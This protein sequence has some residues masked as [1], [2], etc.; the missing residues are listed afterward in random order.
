MA[1]V[2]WKTG[3]SSTW[4]TA[5][6][7]STGTVPTAADDVTISVAGTYTVTTAA[8]DS[9]NSLTLNDATATL[10]ISKSTLTLGTLNDIA[11]KIT[12]AAK[13]ALALTGTQ[14]TA[15]LGASNITSS[16]TIDFNGVLNNTGAT[17]NIGTGGIGVT[18]LAGKITGGTIVDGGTVVG[19]NVVSAM[20]FTAGAG[21]IF[22]G[23]TYDGTLSLTGQAVGLEVTSANGGLITHAQS[24]TGNG[25]IN[26]T[27]VSQPVL[28]LDDTQ[29]LNNATVNFG[30]VA[31]PAIITQNDTGSTPGTLTFGSGLTINQVGQGEIT[32]TGGGTVVGDTV[33][34]A[35]AINAAVAKS[36]LT[37]DPYAF[38]NQGSV[39]VGAAGDKVFVSAK[40][41]TNSSTGT[42]TVTAG[43]L[44]LGAGT[45][46]GSF[47]NHG[48]I[49]VGAAGT[50]ELDLS[51][52][53][54]AQL[55][56]VANSG[57]LLI[58][59]VT[60]LDNTGATLS[61]GTGGFAGPSTVVE[62]TILN[63]TIVDS[64]SG[65]SFIGGKLSNV[66]YDGTLN[67]GASASVFVIGN[68]TANNAAGTGPGT[69]N[70]T[71][72]F[73]NLIFQD[74]QTID[75]ATINIGN[76]TAGAGNSL[77]A[78]PSV[79]G[80]TNTLT[81]GK[82][83]IINHVGTFAGITQNSG[84][85]SPYTV[86]NEGTIKASLAGGTLSI[87]PDNFSNQGTIAVSNG[88]T[89]DSEAVAST[90]AT[91][92]TNAAG[93]SITIG[94][95]ST[96]D[97]GINAAT[98]ALYSAT[99]SGALTLAGG[100]ITDGGTLTDAAGGSIAGFGTVSGAVA[101]GGKFDAS[102]GTLTFSGAVTGTGTAFVETGAKL[103]FGASV[104]A[105]QAV[106][107]VGTGELDLAT[108][109]AFAGTI[110]G[111]SATDTVDLTT[112]GFDS[113]GHANLLAGNVLQVTENGNTYNLQL[114]P[115]Q[116]FSGEFFHLAADLS[117]TG[118]AIT[119]STLP[120]YCRGTQILTP[121]GEVAVEELVIGDQIVTHTGA[122]RSIKWLGRRSYG[123]RFVLGRKDILPVCI[124][125]G[126]LAENV[127]QRDLWISPQHAMYLDGVLIEA[128]DLVN[129]VSVVQA[130]SVNAVD[131]FH[132]ELDSHDVII[133]EGAL[134]ESFIDDNGRGMFQN[135]HEYRTLYADAAEEQKQ[136]CAPRCYDGDEL[137]A[138]RRRVAARAGIRAVTEAFVGRGFVDVA[139]PHRITGWAQNAQHP[140]VP[141]CLDVV[142]GGTRIGS[143]LA[144]R[145][146][147]D[148]ELKGLGSGNHGFEFVLPPGLVVA[149][150][151]VEVRRSYDGALLPCSKRMNQD[152]VELM[153]AAS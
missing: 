62:G 149:A 102:G 85:V 55:G 15:A 83:L 95:G 107:L 67:L 79:T 93:G 59:P 120:C 108:P 42:M 144:N 1:A 89:I 10:A 36:A 148:L 109:A 72:T 132:V 151:A 131:Y 43:T 71:G 35:G 65:M 119:E 116:N 99:N 121:R 34:N 21:G 19:K 8:A 49:T 47:A 106:N 84:N 25:T 22:D 153:R 69:I 4:E 2:N 90:L 129:G 30:N 125:A 127:P 80:Q 64:A 123:G 14:T 135:G 26:L 78:T 97:L 111:I 87:M 75:N 105:G 138:V 126:A 53:T 145:H 140:E 124:K 5:A 23:V 6:N 27:G 28:T 41:F 61:V 152:G 100:T 74:T 137:E 134:S 94:A 136:Y 114:D 7:W 133:A 130:E 46:S 63:G 128:R 29:T 39:T 143:M 101:N 9:A 17:L 112:V 147:A 141:V 60:T 48:T 115:T 117:G 118:T 142:I 20:S 73:A 92:F 13:S 56:T 45:L 57:A 44:D 146:R 96:L 38:I 150:G 16:G 104:A 3:A 51:T 37:I 24:G 88:D 50:L 113:T 82:N 98:N 11:G 58:D 86:I 81:F 70:V 91:N 77:I 122:H 110:D 33:I 68:L 66:T 18:I 139:T 76:G 52:V 54:A 40:N 32:S 103:A 12:I 31:G